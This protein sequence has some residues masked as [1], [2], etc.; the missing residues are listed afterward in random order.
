[1]ETKQK[2][3]HQRIIYTS[4][5]VTLIIGLLLLSF[6][7]IFDIPYY[8]SITFVISGLISVGNYLLLI[9]KTQQ[10][11]EPL[12]KK[13]IKVTSLIN[14]GIFA[15]ALLGLFF[16]FYQDKWVIFAYL[17]GYLILKFVI[18]FQ[19]GLQIKE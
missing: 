17:F 5:I 1:M 6:S 10:S 4:L 14:I 19:Y 15:L 16:L 9:Y 18:F 3:I 7:F 2:R 13:V 8:L 12:L 11:V